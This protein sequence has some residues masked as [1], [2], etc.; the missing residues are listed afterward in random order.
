MSQNIGSVNAWTCC[1]VYACVPFFTHTTL[2]FGLISLEDWVWLLWLSNLLVNLVKQVVNA[3]IIFI[4]PLTLGSPSWPFNC[5]EY[6]FFLFY[7]SLLVFVSKVQ[8]HIKSRKSKKFD[9]CFCVLSHACFA[10]YFRTNDFV[11]LRA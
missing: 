3:S 10:L 1:N 4:T 7:Q 6:L 5:F 2:A 9:R 11:H 8:K